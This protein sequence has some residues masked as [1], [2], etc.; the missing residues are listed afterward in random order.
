MS[1]SG[2]FATSPTLTDGVSSRPENGKFMMSDIR[3]GSRGDS[4]YEYLIKEYLQTVNPSSCCH[5]YRDVAV[6]LSAASF[7]GSA[8]TGL[9]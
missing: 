5:D 6:D 3:L 9:S 1:L 2:W 4:Y 7:T 8:R